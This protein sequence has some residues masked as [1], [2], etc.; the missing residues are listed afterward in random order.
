MRKVYSSRDRRSIARCSGLTAVHD[1]VTP[2]GRQRGL[3]LALALFFNPHTPAIF[4]TLN[5]V[6]EGGGAGYGNRTRLAGLGSQS[7]TTM[8][9]P[10]RTFH[11]CRDEFNTASIIFSAATRHIG[12]PQSASLSVGGN[13][14]SRNGRD[15]HISGP[16]HHD[17]AARWLI[18]A[19]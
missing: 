10:Q 4:Q 7:I 2:F 15:G 16:I 17:F 3:V 14:N 8:L 19:R 12:L 18:L 9:T 5:A 6:Q 11:R 1:E 13:P